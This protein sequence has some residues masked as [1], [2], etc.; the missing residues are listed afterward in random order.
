MLPELHQQKAPK[1]PAR[2]AAHVQTKL[3]TSPYR[4]SASNQQITPSHPL[5]ILNY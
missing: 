2:G 3:E 1:P 4:I 5:K